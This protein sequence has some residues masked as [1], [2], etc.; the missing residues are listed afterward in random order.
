[1]GL[2]TQLLQKGLGFL[3]GYCLGTLVTTSAQRLSALE[4]DMRTITNFQ[5]LF[6]VLMTAELRFPTSTATADWSH[7]GALEGSWRILMKEGVP[8]EFRTRRQSVSRITQLGIPAA[9]VLPELI[10]GAFLLKVKR[11]GKIPGEKGEGRLILGLVSTP[12]L[13]WWRFWDSRKKSGPNAEELHSSK[14]LWH[15][16]PKRGHAPHPYSATDH[17]IALAPWALGWPLIENGKKQV[18]IQQLSGARE[19][20]SKI[21]QKN[22]SKSFLEYL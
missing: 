3:L 20:D 19:P 12:C 15:A 1:M 22:V 13:I 10:S 5:T 11:G 21:A 6:N 9:L 2:D 17:H 16:G 18:P 8:A 14:T 7:R 4:L